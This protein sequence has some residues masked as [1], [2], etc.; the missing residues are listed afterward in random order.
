MGSFNPLY[1]PIGFFEESI[2]RDNPLF[3]LCDSQPIDECCSLHG[4]NEIEENI[5]ENNSN[6]L[7]NKFDFSWCCV[8][9][10]SGDVDFPNLDSKAL[11]DSCLFMNEITDDS[12]AGEN[13]NMELGLVENNEVSNDFLNSYVGCDD[14]IF[15]SDQMGFYLNQDILAESLQAYGFQSS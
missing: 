5:L 14:G 2:I 1:W 11:D 3:E 13:E 4:Q 12:L 15:D 9:K 10:E 8:Q 7:D 6:A